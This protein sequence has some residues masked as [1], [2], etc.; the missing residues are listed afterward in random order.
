LE[1]LGAV[2]LGFLASGRAEP[3]LF[4]AMRPL[5]L[6]A[7][8]AAVAKRPWHERRLAAILMLVLAAASETLLLRYLGAEHVW[9]EAGQGLAV[10]AVL[11]LLC[12]LIVQSACGFG[13]AGRLIVSAAAAALLLASGLVGPWV[14]DL[15]EPAPAPPPAALR[16]KVALMT[17]L[18]LVW[19]EGGPFDPASRPAEAYRALSREFDFVPLDT[20]E[21]ATLA[22]ARVLFLAQPQRLAPSELAALDAWIRSGGRALILADPELAWPSRLPLGDIRRPPP[23]TLLT[24]LL[25][26]WGLSLKASGASGPQ[27][28]SWEGKRLV[29]ERFGRL[30]STGP[31]GIQYGGALARC[32]LGRG[33]AFVIADADLMRDDLWARRGSE[34]YRRTADNPLFIADRLDALF[35]LRRERAARAVTWARRERSPAAGLGLALL[36]I[37]GAG[38]AGLLLRGRRKA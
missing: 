1:L 22:R 7:L 15:V 33:A 5:V 23:T 35:G 21:P 20:L 37:V 8:A 26:H 27:T 25:D 3:L 19:G 6:F 11:A 2:A 14:A 12:D 16:P 34:A 36:P 30:R 28:G 24:P 31:C 17:G 18:P 10:G 38:A 4:F 29:L 32:R 9:R 13:K